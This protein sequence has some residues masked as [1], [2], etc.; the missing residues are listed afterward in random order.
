MRV[1]MAYRC[2]MGD[3]NLSERLAMARKALG[4]TQS[5]AAHRANVCHTAISRWESGAREISL[6]NLVRLADVYECSVDWL[7]GR[8]ACHMVDLSGISHEM[9]Q[10]IRN[11][12]EAVRKE[13]SL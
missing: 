2:C 5:Q 10:V 13:A 9:R 3:S 8:T 1:T 11:F 12:V 4:I 7:L 6:C